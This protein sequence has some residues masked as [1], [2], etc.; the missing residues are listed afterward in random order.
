MCRLLLT[1]KIRL[2]TL[3]HKIEIKNVF[4]HCSLRKQP[5]FGDATTGFPAKWRLRNGRI[6]RP[7]AL[8]GHVTNASFKQWVGVLLMP[9]IDRARKNYLTPEIREETLLREIFYGT[10]IFQQ[11]SMICIGRHV[12]GHA[13]AL[14]QGTSSF[15]HFPWSL[16][17][18]LAW[19]RGSS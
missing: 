9:K 11:S 5:T 12:G 17:Q 16:S 3:V 13:L 14:Q 6:N 2:C 18:K 4:L 10:L 19:E 15:Q 1:L 7:L 8:R